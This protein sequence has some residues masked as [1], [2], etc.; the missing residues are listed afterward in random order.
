MHRPNIQVTSAKEVKIQERNDRINIFLQQRHSDRYS[1]FI[2]LYLRISILCIVQLNVTV[3]SQI[4]AMAI[5]VPLERGE[6]KR[7]GKGAT[8]SCGM[9]KYRT[10]SKL[11][12]TRTVF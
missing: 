8:R 11:N 3:I 7:R 9:I 5:F 2:S 12:F 1:A 4:A 10:F 6:V